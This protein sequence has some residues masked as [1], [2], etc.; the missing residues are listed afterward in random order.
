MI[1]AIFDGNIHSLGGDY[2]Y[3]GA[4]NRS[5]AVSAAA[6]NEALSKVYGQDRLVRELNGK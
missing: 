4:T 6:V 1:G 5:V 3:D 2:G